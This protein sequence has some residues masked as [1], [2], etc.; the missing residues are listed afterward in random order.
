MSRRT[1]K[2]ALRSRSAYFLIS[3][4]DEEIRG[5]KLP[6]K[7]QVL[8]CFAY[9]HIEDKKTFKDCQNCLRWMCSFVECC[10]YSYSGQA[11]CN[12]KHFNTLRYW[13]K[14]EEKYRSQVIT[15]PNCSWKTL[16]WQSWWFVQHCPSG[17]SFYDQDWRR[18]RVPSCPKRKGAA[19][20][21]A[22][23]GYT[24]YQT[25]KSV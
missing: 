18:Q 25:T 16:C 24:F 17:C 14:S 10:E 1:P 3:G 23:Q 21:N 22:R 6:S 9:R 11:A 12:I 5:S 19:R 20:Y 4:G 13:G 2:R 8:R 15:R 7:K